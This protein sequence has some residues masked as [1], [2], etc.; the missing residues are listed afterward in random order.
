MSDLHDIN[1][2]GIDIKIYDEIGSIGYKQVEE[3]LNNDFYNLKNINFNNEDIIIDV[4]AHVGIFSIYLGKKFPNIKIYSLEPSF[5]N[6]KNLIE[7]LK[8]NNCKNIYP[9]NLGLL[10]KTMFKNLALSS[11][12]IDHSSMINTDGLNFIE[13]N[14][15]FIS[16]DNLINLLEL[17][18]VSLL[19]IDCEGAE[20]LIFDKFKD[21]D[22]IDKLVIEIHS[23]ENLGFNRSQLCEKLFKNLGNRLLIV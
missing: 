23:C 7:N 14:C 22:I 1:I 3:E 16:I 21:Y 2:L 6:F 8:I 18:K 11:K 10:D 4:G 9:L 17:K 15:F 19:K 13:E 12:T 5:S 20:Y